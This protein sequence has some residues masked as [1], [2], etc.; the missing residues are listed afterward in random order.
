MII[1][2]FG[3]RINEPKM[4]WFLQVKYHWKSVTSR[5]YDK[6]IVAEEK[7]IVDDFG[8]RGNRMFLWGEGVVELNVRKSDCV[9]GSVSIAVHHGQAATCG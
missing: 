1:I 4:N 2:S 8:I 5:Q 9:N 3:I 6:L 7:E